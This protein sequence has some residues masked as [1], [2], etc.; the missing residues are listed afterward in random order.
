M[1]VHYSL[2][3][4]LRRACKGLFPVVLLAGFG[5]GWLG[6]PDSSLFEVIMR[7]V[8]VTLL[9]AHLLIKGWQR[10]LFSSGLKNPSKWTGPSIDA[11][12]ITPSVDRVRH[13]YLAAH[14]VRSSS[15]G[16][17]KDL[18]ALVRGAVRRMAYFRDR[19]FEKDI[20][21]PAV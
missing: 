11:T 18:S 17:R 14:H 7:L 4:C 16:P 2:S 6:G 15:Y 12:V 19:K 13:D 3:S 9:V 5:T 10:S 8:A 1:N 20:H 21:D